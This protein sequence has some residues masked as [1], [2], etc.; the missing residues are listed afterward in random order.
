MPFTF[1]TDS[2]ATA[3]A[4]QGI[5]TYTS[6]VYGSYLE[7]VLKSSSDAPE[8]LDVA[9]WAQ[10]SASNVN[11]FLR[12]T[13]NGDG[14]FTEVTWKTNLTPANLAL[15]LDALGVSGFYG[16]ME[17]TDFDAMEAILTA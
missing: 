13:V 12:Y 9:I 16:T 15:E 3:I 7:R 17:S 1:T 11:E 14:T 10:T 5:G 6:A 8:T 4:E 2:R